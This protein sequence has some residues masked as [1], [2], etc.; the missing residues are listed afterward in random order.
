MTPTVSFFPM[1]SPSNSGEAK[2]AAPSAEKNSADA[3]FSRMLDHAVRENPGRKNNKP[4][5]T[6][7]P[8]PK[9]SKP[10]VADK[11][12]Q[13][14]TKLESAP[15]P[16]RVKN[17]KRDREDTEGLAS[18]GN[19]IPLATPTP[20]PEKP[21]ATNATSDAETTAV[22]A[23]EGQCAEGE[24]PATTSEPTLTT[25]AETPARSSLN[26]TGLIPT[27]EPADP[28]EVSLLTTISQPVTPEVSSAALSALESTA[29]EPPALQMGDAFAS[30]SSAVMVTT[31]PAEIPLEQS[32]DA[33][34]L[35]PPEDLP[36]STAPT[37]TA[38]A[39][40][41]AKSAAVSAGPETTTAN[42]T[43]AAP[44]MTAVAVAA[45]TATAE[46]ATMPEELPRSVRAVRR[47]RL[48]GLETPAG[49][50]GAK[51]SETM[52]TVI[53]KEELA[54]GTEQFLPVSSPNA[55]SALRNLPGELNRN[56]G[57]PLAGTE[58]LEAAAKTSASAA[59]SA[60]GTD[61]EALLVRSANP[62]TR[63]SEV[64]SREIRMFKRGGDDLVEVVLTPDAK[65]Q[66]SL[67][68]QWREG[69]VEV[70]A[71]CD[72]GDYQSLNTQW[73]QLQSSLASHGVRLSHLSERVTTGFTEFFNN[74]NFAQQRGREEH[75]HHPAHPAETLP[76]L[77]GSVVKPGSTP[78]VRRSN[79]LFDSWA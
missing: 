42:P 10:A 60:T 78:A 53:K 57:T 12:G 70:Q 74:P 9:E 50:G 38:I 71:R 22:A 64:I 61:S 69:Q 4:A 16:A 24:V 20:P 36:K 33:A 18:A 30:M 56:A 59:H 55:L 43:P 5:P 44:V 17:N 72:L 39:A 47:A 19:A 79:R 27:T 32:Q 26:L 7:R 54:G 58:A 13:A 63:I 11:T 77:P 6:E 66:I 1:T 51:S 3:P 76:A 2:V 21:I 73:A 41:S 34:P 28:E 37:A 46:P 62:M 67:R 14:E 65:T 35:L 25:A 29:A 8:A 49:T 48:E 52:K 31:T 40:T 75:S 68:L 23:V 45:G 15:R